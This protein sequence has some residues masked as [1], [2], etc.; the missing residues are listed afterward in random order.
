MRVEG[1][2]REFPQGSWEEKPDAD[3]LA[4]ARGELA[5]KTGLSA[6]TM[7][8]LGHLFSAYGYC[9][10]GLHVLLATDLTAG[11]AGLVPA[12]SGRARWTTGVLIAL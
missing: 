7:T 1:R 2:Y 3:P 6:G 4:L 11:E 9:D 5:E 8:P 12:P 10:Q